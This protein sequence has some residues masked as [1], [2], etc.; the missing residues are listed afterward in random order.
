MGNCCSSEISSTTHRN[1]SC[2][3]FASVSSLGATENN[4]SR[5]LP[6]I[7]SHQVTTF[8]PNRNPMNPPLS[9]SLSRS[10]NGLSLVAFLPTTQVF[11]EKATSPAS[12]QRHGVHVSTSQLSMTNERESQQHPAID[13]RACRSGN[14]GSIVSHNFFGGVLSSIETRHKDGIAHRV[15][16]R[17]QREI[18]SSSALY[19][20]PTR[21]TSHRKR[22]QKSISRSASV[23]DRQNNVIGGAPRCLQRWC[24]DD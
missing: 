20:S 15:K 21:H 3:E 17:G 10:K 6:T 4:G 12:L 22:S 24:N 23:S 11:V 5:P 13:S 14:P 7:F 1:E 16:D 2:L 9:Q 8:A 19:A 18:S